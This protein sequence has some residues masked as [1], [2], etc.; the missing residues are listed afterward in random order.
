LDFGGLI[1]DEIAQIE[2]LRGPQSALWGSNATAGVISIITK[3]GRRNDLVGTA[4]GEVGFDGSYAG[5]LAL[6]GGV[7]RADFALSAA[8]R[9]SAGHD[10]SDTAGGQDDEDENV[11]LNAKGNVDVTDWIGL[12]GTL[13]YTHRESDFDP[14]DFNGDFSVFPP[15]VGPTYGL[16]IEGDNVRTTDEFYGS[17]FAEVTTLGGLLIH[18]P[19]VEYTAVDD[20]NTDAGVRTSGSEGQRLHLSHQTTAVFDTPSFAGASHQLTAAIEYERETNQNLPPASGTQL[21]ERER[22]QVGFIGEYRGSFFDR[23]DLQFGLRHD[24]NDAFDDATTYSV[25]GALQLAEATQLYGSV[26]TGVTNPTFSEQFGFFPDFFIGNPGLTPEKSFGWDVGLRQSLF[27]GKLSADIAYFDATLEDEIF[28]RFLPG[29]LSTPDN[30][31]GES[32]RRGVEVGLT[33]Q[34]FDF[35]SLTAAYTYTDSKEISGGRLVGEV[36]RPLHTASLSATATGLDGRGQLTVDVIY[37][38]QMLDFDFTDPV[39]GS[40]RTD[41]DAYTLVNLNASYEIFEGAE[42]VGRVENVFDQ[43]YQEVFGYAAPGVTAFVG[44]R[45]SY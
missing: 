31:D 35:L 37:N 43:D 26:G 17:L 38:G 42:I 34:P 9:F 19:R 16:V 11:T 41:L 32:E 12:G 27:D 2:V 10:V 30:R 24:R 13:R 20:E 33:A 1:V 28:T 39:L 5:R 21:T 40:V 6:R 25:S 29:F 7:E 8:Y 3:Q 44:F 36:R 18:R 23:L 4:D 45:A 15:I 14:Q 22:E